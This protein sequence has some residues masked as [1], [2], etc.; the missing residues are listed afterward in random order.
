MLDINILNVK[1]SQFLFLI[2]YSILFYPLLIF[3]MG[4]IVWVKRRD[5]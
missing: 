3:V 1:G 4:Y 2:S 5:L